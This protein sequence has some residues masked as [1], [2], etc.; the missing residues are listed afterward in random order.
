MEPAIRA[1]EFF[2]VSAW[3]YLQHEPRPGDVIAFRF[4]L[5][6]RI[7]FIKRVIAVG[8][9]TVA[10]VDGVTI[11]DG[12][13][14]H[15]PY[16]NSTNTNFLRTMAPAH[17]PRACYFVMGDNRSVQFDSRV[18]GCVPQADVIGKVIY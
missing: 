9:A 3:T 17:V 4:S 18:W 1:N 2:I 11:V 16:V 13:R 7:Q 8:E 5:D 15:E 14:L 6:P 10:I 12:T